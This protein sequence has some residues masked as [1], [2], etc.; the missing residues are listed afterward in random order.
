MADKEYIERKALI[1][2]LIDNRSFYPAVVKSA[3]E[4]AT[5]V[6]VIEVVRCCECKH[7]CTGYCV[8]DVGGRT[9]MLRMNRDDFCSYG[10]RGRWDE[11]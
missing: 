3:I 4:S 2:D 8:R 11:L 7:Y 9:N 1:R 10:E 6:D 5:V